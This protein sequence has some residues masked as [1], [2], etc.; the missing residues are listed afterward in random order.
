MQWAAGSCGMKRRDGDTETRRG[1]RRTAIGGRRT[2]VRGH[3]LVDSSSRFKVPS[4][5]LSAK[6]EWFTPLTAHCLPFTVYQTLVKIIP[7]NG[8]CEVHGAGKGRGDRV[9]YMDTLS[10]FLHEKI[11]YQFFLV[12]IN[13]LCPNANLV[14]W[15]NV[16]NV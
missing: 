8:S 2:E 15:F 11:Q 1:G 16:S 13:Q 14:C 5:K 3:R 12:P 7:H 9:K 4:S 6:N 10:F